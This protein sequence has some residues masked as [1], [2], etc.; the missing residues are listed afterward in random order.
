M[1][2]AS[3]QEIERQART[4]GMISMEQDGFMKALE[5]MTTI[6]EI[7]RVQNI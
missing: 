7:L 2:H 3:A 1:Q 6:E 4:V 5:G